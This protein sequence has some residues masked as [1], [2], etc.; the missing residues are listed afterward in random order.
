MR[1]LEAAI[2]ELGEAGDPESDD[3]IHDARRR[4]KKI[5]AIIRLVRPVLDKTSRAV[6]ADLR[7]VSGLLAPVSDGR[8]IIETLNHIADRYRRTLPPRILAAARDGLLRREAETD[9]EAN[10]RGLIQLAAGTLRADRK[11]VKHWE[12]SADGFRAVAP[13]LEESYRRARR[14]MIQSWSKPKASNFHAWRQH[15]KDH[16]FHLRLIQ[17]RCGFHLVSYERQIEL[18]DGVLGEYH[19]VILLRDVFVTEEQLPRD[20]VARCMRVVAR[21]QRALRRHSQSIGVR[22]YSE[23]PRE[24]V[25]RVRRLWQSDDASTDGASTTSDHNRP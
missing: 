2:D 1:Q 25:R 12:V 4:V 13:G 24:F 23:R 3:A 7:T 8:G 16:W 10:E 19:N 9:R 21:Y 17:Q 6:D 20:E 5:R 14:L 15:V 18:L 11:R 22:V